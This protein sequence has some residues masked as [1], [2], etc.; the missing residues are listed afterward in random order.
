[1]QWSIAGMIHGPV[2]PDANMY[3]RLNNL[4]PPIFE[5]QALNHGLNHTIAAQ[6]CDEAAL[7]SARHD[8]G[9]GLRTAH[10][11][12]HSKRTVPHHRSVPV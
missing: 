5:S 6:R 9:A 8:Q 3:I 12:T 7:T 11:V 2:E 4:R 10:L 1:M